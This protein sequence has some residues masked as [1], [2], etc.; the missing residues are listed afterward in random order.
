MTQS[1]LQNSGLEGVNLSLLS[2]AKEGNSY[3]SGAAGAPAIFGQTNS[4]G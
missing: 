2:F 3:V 1:N 4:N